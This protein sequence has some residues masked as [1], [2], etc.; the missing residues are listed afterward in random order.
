[1]KPSRVGGADS[2]AGFGLGARGVNAKGGIPLGAPLVKLLAM[3]SEARKP[4]SCRTRC[5]KL[6]E[7]LV[8]TRLLWPLMNSTSMR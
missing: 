6:E 4:V 3:K 8:S 1:M 2:M 7:K 5:E